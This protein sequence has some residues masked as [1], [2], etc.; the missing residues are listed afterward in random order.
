MGPAVWNCTGG[1]Q[2]CEANWYSTSPSPGPCHSWFLLRF[3][4][5]PGEVPWLERI[6]SKPRSSPTS[7]SL[8]PC[9][10]NLGP[11]ILN[12]IPVEWLFQGLQRSKT[13]LFSAIC[14]NSY[15]WGFADKLIT[16]NLVEVCCH[17][18]NLVKSSLS[19]RQLCMVLQVK[20][21]I[22]PQ[23]ICCLHLRLFHIW[24]RALFPLSW[25]G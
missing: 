22:Y 5:C 7:M 21:L 14:I 24:H 9:T 15:G 25:E 19:A 8:W 6:N 23:I 20:G 1:T 13:S 3:R 4:L 2:H 17:P 18:L 10:F 16:Q 12:L 11:H